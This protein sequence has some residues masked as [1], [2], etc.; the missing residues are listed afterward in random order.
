VILTFIKTCLINVNDHF[1]CSNIFF[2]LFA[3][4][5]AQVIS[6]S[7]EFELKLICVEIMPRSFNQ[8]D[9]R[10]ICMYCSLKIVIT[11]H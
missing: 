8:R 10:L 2:A 3:L 9:S 1:M 4:I 11:R 7:I 5:L 6:Y